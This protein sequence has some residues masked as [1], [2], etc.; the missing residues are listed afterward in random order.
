MIMGSILRYA[1]FDSG[2]TVMVQANMRNSGSILG[3]VYF[4]TPQNLCTNDILASHMWSPGSTIRQHFLG[5][6]NSLCRFTNYT[7]ALS[8]SLLRRMQ[9]S[10]AYSLHR[11]YHVVGYKDIGQKTVNR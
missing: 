1:T 9:S 11:H 6:V 8:P 2:T 7:C 3:S 10:I 5:L 4:R